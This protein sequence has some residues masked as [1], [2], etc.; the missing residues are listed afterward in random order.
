[1]LAAGHA[2]G[3][4]AFWRLPVPVQVTGK[5][6]EFELRDDSLAARLRLRRRQLGLLQIEAARRMGVSEFTY[7]HWE[8]GQTHPR[9][10]HRDV[11][12]WFLDLGQPHATR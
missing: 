10:R 12:E 2:H 7:I 6:P 8:K 4:V 3:Y 5:K 1:M 11:I 9:H